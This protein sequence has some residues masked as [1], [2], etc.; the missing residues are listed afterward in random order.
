M[1]LEPRSCSSQLMSISN[2]RMRLLLRARVGYLC[3]RSISSICPGSSPGHFFV[4]N[5][6]YGR[7]PRSSR[8]AFRG[9]GAAHQIPTRD[10][11]TRARVWPPAEAG[12]PLSPSVDRSLVYAKEARRLRHAHVVIIVVICRHRSLHQRESGEKILDRP[13][14]I[15]LG[16]G[17][18]REDPIYRS[19]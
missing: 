11:Q 1:L 9:D 15:M 12:D 2:C 4:Q 10:P 16:W 13:G 8:V 18:F 3:H 5:C 19:F 6:S 7:R 17:R 14:R